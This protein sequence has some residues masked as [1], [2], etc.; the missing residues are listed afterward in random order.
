MSHFDHSASSWD[1]P[2]KVSMM[3]TLAEKVKENVDLGD[4]LSILDFG[5]GTGLF[6]LEFFDNAKSLIGMDTSTGMLEVFDEKTKKY[7]NIKSLKLDLESTEVQ[8]VE[9]D[10]K[11]DLVVSSMTF[12]HLN[13]PIN[14]LT[15]LKNSLNENG[16]I[17]V[18]DLEK[19]DGSFHPNNEEMGVKHYGFSQDELKSWADKLNLKINICTINKVSKNGKEYGQFLAEFH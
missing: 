15:K 6:G 18:V 5:C 19:E 13:N 11:F 4:N 16:K 7:S 14:V 1:S 17:L 2:S 8:R 10:E 12:H 3:M 9:T